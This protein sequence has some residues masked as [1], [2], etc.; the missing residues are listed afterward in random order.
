MRT[1][2]RRGLQPGQH[3]T[4][5]GKRRQDGRAVGRGDGPTYRPADGAWQQGTAVAFSPDGTQVATGC[6]DDGRLWD[7][8]TGQPLGLPMKHADKVVAVA[9]SP[10]GTKA[11]NR[12]L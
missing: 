11:C 9:F 7:A 1:D 12:Q 3:E 5:D 10:D 8:A 2:R 4:R 6:G